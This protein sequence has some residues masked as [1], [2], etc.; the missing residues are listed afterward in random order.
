MWRPEE[1][2]EN[3]YD[4]AKLA[5]TILEYYRFDAGSYGGMIS[6]S[7][8][9]EGSQAFELGADAML[10]ALIK[11]GIPNDVYQSYLHGANLAGFIGLKEPHSYMG[12]KGNLVFIPDEEDK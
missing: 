2:W 6:A 3:P 11:E 4:K 9:A 8:R 10:K 1:G 12:R 5:D 7:Q